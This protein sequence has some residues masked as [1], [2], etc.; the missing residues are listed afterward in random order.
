MNA[1]TDFAN[2]SITNFFD[3]TPTQT[4]FVWNNDFLLASTW[5]KHTKGT[6]TAGTGICSDHDTATPNWFTLTSSFVNTSPELLTGI[7]LEGK[8]K[9]SWF[10]MVNSDASTGSAAAS[11]VLSKADSNKFNLHW[12]EWSHGVFSASNQLLPNTS[13]TPL[14]LGAYSNS[15]EWPNPMSSGLDKITG[16]TQKGAA[17]TF[18]NYDKDMYPSMGLTRGNISWLS[19]TDGPWEYDTTNGLTTLDFNYYNSLL[20]EY[21]TAVAAYNTAAVTYSDLAKKYNDDVTARKAQIADPSS[22]SFQTQIAIPPVP[23]LAFDAPSGWPG[24]KFDSSL[25][26]VAAVAAS[27]S[28]KDN[29]MFYTQKDAAGTITH[30][31]KATNAKDLR[32]AWMQTATTPVTGTDTYANYAGTLHVMGH[33]GQEIIG[34]DLAATKTALQALKGWRFNVEASGSEVK[35]YMMVGVYPYVQNEA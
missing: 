26:D 15:Y 28:N 25:A 23:C 24:Y 16:G 22:S 12:A 9:C 8:Y 21:N 5:Q 2:A 13:V 17:V 31:T 35:H 34:T 7:K 30:F 11:F 19:K 18:T 10:I 27:S 3:G 20:S 33:F 29:T 6:T 4:D 14:F 32:A 1:P